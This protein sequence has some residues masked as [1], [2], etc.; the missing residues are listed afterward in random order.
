MRAAGHTRVQGD[1]ADVAAHHLDD[2][3]AVVRFRRGVQTVDRVRG[4]RHRGVEAEGVVGGVGVVIDRLRHAHHRNAVVGEPLG[5]LERAFAADR[6]QR[7]DARVV[8]VRLDLVDAR[9]EF[10]RV[11]AA[12]AQDRAAAQQDR[13]DERVVVQVRA[14]VVH[15][16]HPAVLVTDDR[17][18][19]F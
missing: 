10:I 17:G 5:T 14:Q 2:E 4:H 11:E 13:V 19:E 3:D 15:E 12:G 8:E 9:L 6:D 7:V 18:P 16:T 1:P